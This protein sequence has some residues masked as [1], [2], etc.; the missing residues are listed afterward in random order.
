MINAAY[1]IEYEDTS[2][3]VYSLVGNK[4]DMEGTATMEK[5]SKPC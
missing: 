3:K 2:F 5:F 4:I 1:K